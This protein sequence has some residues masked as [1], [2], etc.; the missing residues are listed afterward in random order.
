MRVCARLRSSR[1]R[2]SSRRK[3]TRE[4]TGTSSY[5]PSPK[6]KPRSSTGT[7]ASSMGRNFPFRKTM[8]APLLEPQPQCIPRAAEDT[9]DLD[10]LQGHQRVF[11]DELAVV[12]HAQRTD[13]LAL[14]HGSEQR[15]LRQELGLQLLGLAL[16][17]RDDDVVVES[18]FHL[19]GRALPYLDRLHRLVGR[20][21]LDAVEELESPVEQLLRFLRARRLRGRAEQHREH[22]SAAAVRRRDQA[23]ARG[24]GVAG[25]DAVDARIEPEQA[26]AVRLR[27]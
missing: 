9:G 4:Y 12:R 8:L 26:V 10:R 23:I 14:R 5:T 6:M 18:G 11:A 27:D 17:H 2:C 1:A 16:G 22:A 15:L 25:L 13:P 19:A 20:I 3:A 7:R 21:K 24:L